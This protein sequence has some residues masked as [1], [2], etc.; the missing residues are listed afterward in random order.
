MC[1]K[2]ESSFLGQSSSDIG[3]DYWT[4]LIDEDMCEQVLDNEDDAPDSTVKVCNIRRYGPPVTVLIGICLVLVFVK[5]ICG[6][7]R[8]CTGC[9]AGS[10]CINVTNT[11][12]AILA[13]A[14]MMIAV[15]IYGSQC[16]PD[17]LSDE[18]GTSGVEDS[19]G[20][21]FWCLLFG[22]LGMCLSFVLSLME[23]CMKKLDLVGEEQGPTVVSG[24]SAATTSASTSS[25]AADSKV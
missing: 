19:Y 15:I 18:A 25:S 6:L 10:I 24:T 11:I 20:P 3:C 1:I 14:G 2:F 7:V 4:E 9:C 17:F 23:C 13:A 12:L 21:G 16:Y 8:C 22:G 5:A